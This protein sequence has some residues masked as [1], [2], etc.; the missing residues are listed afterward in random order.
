MNIKLR[1]LTFKEIDLFDIIEQQSIEDGYMEFN[2]QEI[3]DGYYS[4]S[5]DPEIGYYKLWFEDIY[6]CKYLPNKD[7]AAPTFGDCVIHAKVDLKKQIKN[8]LG[9]LLIGEIL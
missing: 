3:F 6:G 2:S 9:N 4:I 1:E 5:F 7:T 8:Q